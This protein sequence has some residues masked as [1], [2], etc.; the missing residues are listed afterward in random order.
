VSHELRTP[1]MG[2]MGMSEALGL[3]LAG[4][5]TERQRR[6][7][8]TIADSGTRLQ[9]VINSMLR[10]TSLPA[11]PSELHREPCPVA[12]LCKTAVRAVE[13]TIAARE[14]VLTVDTGEPELAVLGNAKGVAQALENLLDNAA[15]FTPVGGRIGLE[16]AAAEDGQVTFTVWDTGIGIAPEQQ[17]VIFNPFT[18]A[19]ASLARRYSGLGLGLAYVRRIAELHEGTV[20]VASTP[21]EGSRFVI[22]LP[23]AAAFLVEPLA[24]VVCVS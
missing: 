6:Y 12:A 21:G 13:P 7:V 18:P 5:L 2:V 3:E 4:P 14:Q 24:A 15:R 8:Q 10:Y 20:T 17:A 11:G 16:A 19:D 9:E 23:R 22:T 1:L